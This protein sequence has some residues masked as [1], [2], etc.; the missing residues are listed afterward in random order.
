[1][2]CNGRIQLANQCD[3]VDVDVDVDVIGVDVDVDV[4]GRAKE[5]SF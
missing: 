3:G 4:N 5:S 2:S 1:M